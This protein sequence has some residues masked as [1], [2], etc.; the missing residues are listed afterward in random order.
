M[1]KELIVLTMTTWNYDYSFSAFS[2]V[3]ENDLEK[4]R[5]N[6]ED[7]LYGMYK[8]EYYEITDE[9]IDS[10]LDKEELYKFKEQVVKTIVEK[11]FDKEHSFVFRALKSKRG[12]EGYEIEENVRHV[13]RVR[14][15]NVDKNDMYING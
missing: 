2:V 5:K 8:R 13:V 1:N 10:I 4:V 15:I 14:I 11:D 3:N 9:Y 7:Y 6:I 12:A